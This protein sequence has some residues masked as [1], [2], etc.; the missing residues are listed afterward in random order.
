MR[1]RREYDIKLVGKNLKRLREKK[2]LS[3]ED[4]RKYLCLGSVQAIYKYEEGR[5]YPQ[6]DTLF[7]LMELYGA[8]F[9][10]LTYEQPIF[11]PP[12][13]ELQWDFWVTK[14]DH[15]KEN[16]EI[17]SPHASGV[18]LIN[19][20]IMYYELCAKKIAKDAAG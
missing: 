2:K 5:N 13:T 15:R 6:T 9:Q 20:L 3:V 1:Y 10:E 16:L 12:L 7:A 17:I 4:V 11:R 19:R 8:E 14:K 18:E